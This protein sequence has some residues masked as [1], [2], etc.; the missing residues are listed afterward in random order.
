MVDFYIRSPP[1]KTVDSSFLWPRIAGPY[2]N[3]VHA[4]A[5]F[6]GSLLFGY[7]QGILG[8]LYGDDNSRLI[9]EYWKK[10]KIELGKK[11]IDI[12]RVNE[13]DGILNG[14]ILVES[15]RK[16]NAIRNKVKIVEV[17]TRFAT[18]ERKNASFREM[19]L[20][21][22]CDDNYYQS[23]FQK[24][25]EYVMTVFNDLR[26]PYDI[27]S[28]RVIM[29]LCAHANASLYKLAKEK[30]CEP[31]DMWGEEGHTVKV[32]R[33]YL[34]VALHEKE[35]RVDKGYFFRNA[36]ALFNPWRRRLGLEEVK[37]SI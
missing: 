1:R 16:R 20:S 26:K 14:T 30:D 7:D 13:R 29:S 22:D 32:F 5:I 21:C 27:P 10:Q 11:V 25:N 23:W 17:T 15:R 31:F 33:D 18:Q 6:D 35:S 19:F 37:P 2:Y 8:K 28:A 4:M 12:S 3:A 24:A 9:E 34:D 36:T